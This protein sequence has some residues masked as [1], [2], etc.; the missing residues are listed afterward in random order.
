MKCFWL[1]SVHF[2]EYL[3][4]LVVRPHFARPVWV[5]G[6]QHCMFRRWKPTPGADISAGW[7]V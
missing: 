1:W 5:F 2:Q 6:N 3:K 7:E 4:M